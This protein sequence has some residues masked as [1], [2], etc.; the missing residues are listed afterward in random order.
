MVAGRQV[1][2]NLEGGPVVG[3]PG[4]ENKHVVDPDAHTVIH[5]RRE[6]VIAGVVKSDRPLPAGRPVVAVDA[7]GRP[8]LTPIVI[9]LVLIPL[10][11]GRTGE[12][13]IVPILGTPGRVGCLDAAGIERRRQQRQQQ[14]PD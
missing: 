10:E 2:V 4:V 14:G 12:G 1:M 11:H 13:R 7:G 5:R 9:Q 6:P 8:P 3:R